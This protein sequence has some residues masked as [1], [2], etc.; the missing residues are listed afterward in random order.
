MSTAEFSE[1]ASA[2]KWAERV[3]IV[4]FERSRWAVAAEPV[5]PTL[6]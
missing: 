6:S 4:A 1:S 3:T 2:V 5:N